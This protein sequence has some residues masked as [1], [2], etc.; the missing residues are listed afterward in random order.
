MARMHR[1]KVLVQRF[2]HNLV[3][4]AD[5]ERV[6]LESVICKD[7][8]QCRA[9]ETFNDLKRRAALPREDHGPYRDWMAVVRKPGRGIAPS[10]ANIGRG[11]VIRF[12]ACAASSIDRKWESIPTRA[13][14]VSACTADLVITGSD[15]GENPFRAVNIGNLVLGIGRPVLVTASNVD[16]VMGKTILVAWKDTRERDER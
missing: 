10:G 11:R 15:K 9:G 7:C 12:P 2:S 4:R 13:L 5:N 16:H 6:Y 3:C 1:K 14:S 8:D